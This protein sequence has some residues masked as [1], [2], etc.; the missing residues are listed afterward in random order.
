MGAE[1]AGWG[2]RA[3]GELLNGH[4]RANNENHL[5][6]ER[7]GYESG[8]QGR[9]RIEEEPSQM[10]KI[11]GGGPP[12]LPN[13]GL[14]TSEDTQAGKGAGVGVVAGERK[15]L[16]PIPQNFPPRKSS[17]PP[18]LPPFLGPGS[19]LGLGEDWLKGFG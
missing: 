13:L 5:N 18:Q 4:G 10:P 1:K 2:R 16:P 9:G 17:P 11:G 14:R 3:S 15:P 7:Y 12:R 19:G 6:N 8:G